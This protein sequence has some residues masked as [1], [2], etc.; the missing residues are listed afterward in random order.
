MRTRAILIS[1]ICNLAV[2]SAFAQ[3]TLTA[4]DLQHHR[5]VLETINGEALPATENKG[6]IPEL[7][8]GEQM[9]VSG[10]TGCNQ[11]NG[12][13]VLRDGFFLI[14]AMVS[15]G[16]MCP[17]PWGDI[18]IA[19]QTALGHESTISLDAEK[20]LTLQTAGTTLVFR[21]E[22]WVAAAR[23]PNDILIPFL[24]GGCTEDAGSLLESLNSDRLVA[25]EFIATL[26]RWAA[27]RR[28]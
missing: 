11:V 27:Y 2:S 22:D 15:T 20:N 28:G 5:W 3:S 23:C 18:E 13:A 6:K 8:F 1:L 10:N 12:Q 14:E 24:R 7:D 16:M 17:P 9:L 21:L 19:V 25:I 26:S 4:T